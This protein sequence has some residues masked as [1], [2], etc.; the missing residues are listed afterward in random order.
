MIEAPADLRQV[1]DWD[2]RTFGL[3]F[4]EQRNDAIIQLFGNSTEC[5]NS[6]IYVDS[7]DIAAARSDHLAEVAFVYALSSAN[8]QPRCQH[9]IE[10]AGRTTALYMSGNC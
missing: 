3:L 10:R 9:S 1:H 7:D 2:C 8:T 5:S 4:V 6:L